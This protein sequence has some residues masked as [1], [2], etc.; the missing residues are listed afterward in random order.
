[1]L[2]KIRIFTTNQY[3]MK[4]SLLANLAIEDMIDKGIT[5][6]KNYC[7][8]KESTN[9]GIYVAYFETKKD[10]QLSNSF[11]YC[12]VDNEGEVIN[13]LCNY[14]FEEYKSWA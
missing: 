2:H 5:V 9:Q 8:R 6:D 10:M 3:I 7:E 4:A 13:M 14:K 11:L 12:Q 1:M